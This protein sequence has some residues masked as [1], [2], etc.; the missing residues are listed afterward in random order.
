VKRHPAL[1]PFSRDHN[2]GLILSRRLMRTDP[3]VAERARTDWNKELADHFR[4]EE[5]V[6]GP[7]SSAEDLDRMVR[8]HEDLRA[9]FLAL[10]RASAED[11]RMLGSLL[12]AHIRWEER[13]WFPRIEA[14]LT[15][16]SIASLSEASLLLEQ[17]RWEIDPLRESLVRRRL[18]GS[19][20]V[21]PNR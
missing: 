20:A 11:L 15:E 4:V 17:R 9:R 1:E 21:A 5:E 18:Q 2:D 7:L 8:D 19:Q 16:E 13:E 14:T 3:G 12:E 6:L 10:D